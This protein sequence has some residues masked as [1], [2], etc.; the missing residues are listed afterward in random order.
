LSG[1]RGV[2]RGVVSAIVSPFGRELVA[3]S[4]RAA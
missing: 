1:C 2:G 4:A 3:A